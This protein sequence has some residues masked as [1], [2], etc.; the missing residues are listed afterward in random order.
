MA[1]LGKSLRQ[2]FVDY[3]PISKV[4][5]TKFYVDGSDYCSDLLSA[6]EDAKRLVLMTGLHFM[7]DFELK[8]PDK[9]SELSKVLK[10]VSRRAKVFLLVNQ[11]W[12]DEGQIADKSEQI[13]A[14]VAKA[15][16][17]VMKAGELHGYLPQTYELFEELDGIQNIV[18]RT[19]LHP[20]RNLFGTHHQKTVVVDDKIAFLGG[21]DL[22]Y[23]DGDRWDTPQHKRMYRAFGRTQSFWHDVHMRVTGEPVAF[24]RDNFRQRWEGGELNTLYRKLSGVARGKP[25]YYIRAKRDHKPPKLP[26][27]VPPSPRWYPKRRE[28]P[29]EH[30]VQI[31]RSMPEHDEWNRLKPKWNRSTRKWERSAKDAYLVGIKAARKYIYSENQ[32]IADE[33]IWDELRKAAERNFKN[34]SFRIILVVPYE[35]LAAAGLGANQDLEVTGMIGGN[36]QRIKDELA[37]GGKGIKGSERFGMYSPVIYEGME[38]PQ[39]YVH[40]KILI[41]DDAWA[42]RLGNIDGQGRFIGLSGKN[43]KLLSVVDPEEDTFDYSFHSAVYVGSKTAQAVQNW[44][45]SNKR[46]DQRALIVCRVQLVPYGQKSDKHNAHPNFTVSREM[47]LLEEKFFRANTPP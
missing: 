32:W 29:R 22:T 41:V 46:N 38:R 26:H 42:L 43:Y 14:V 5:E 6:L 45:I 20:N 39:I 16:N 17:T 13:W 7:K 31:V 9:S 37:R 30:I 10:R 2:W 28:T 18:C 47:L 40:S 1:Y 3:L 35:G 34:D 8:R 21:I 25:K 23:L 12:E 4:E 27:W 44:L 11:F 15:R 33:H 19:D 24:V 36:V